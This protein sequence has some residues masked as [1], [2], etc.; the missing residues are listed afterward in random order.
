MLI[1]NYNRAQI[2]R[3]PNWMHIAELRLREYEKNHPRQVEIKVKLDRID[4]GNWTKEQ[5][6]IDNNY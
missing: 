5:N 6:Y 3:E 1:D 4:N 2:F